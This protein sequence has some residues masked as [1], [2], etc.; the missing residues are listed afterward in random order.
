MPAGMDALFLP[1]PFWALW[2][3]RI[4][5]II[6]NESVLGKTKKGSEELTQIS[7]QAVVAYTARRTYFWNLGVGGTSGLS[8]RG[9]YHGWILRLG[10]EYFQRKGFADFP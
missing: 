10:L 6:A 1:P 5:F 2:V 3:H 7:S 8:V 9:I 4:H